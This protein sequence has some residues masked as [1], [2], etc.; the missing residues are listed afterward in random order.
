MEELAYIRL[1][2]LL[3]IS[4]W[5]VFEI[6]LP[7]M[8]KVFSESRV[9]PSRFDRV[10]RM[11]VQK[12]Q[13]KGKIVSEYLICLQIYF[14]INSFFMNLSGSIHDSENFAILKSDLRSRDKRLEGD[15]G[16]WE[17]KGAFHNI[18]NVTLVAEVFMLVTRRNAFAIYEFKA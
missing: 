2:F 8:H 7:F 16:R 14:S 6:V 18:S 10:M 15:W 3:Q 1:V 12:L 5:R 17:R 9:K 13:V 11:R 4:S